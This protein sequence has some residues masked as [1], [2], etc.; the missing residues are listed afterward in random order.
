[1][2]GLLIT[3]IVCCSLMQRVTMLESRQAQQDVCTDSE[4]NRLE[5]ELICRQ[6]LIVTSVHYHLGI[7]DSAWS[8]RDLH[9]NV[10][11]QLIS[12]LHHNNYISITSYINDHQFR[13]IQSV[14]HVMIMV[15]SIQVDLVASCSTASSALRSTMPGSGRT[16]SQGSG[17]ASAAPSFVRHLS[18]SV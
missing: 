10:L 12:T 5:A 4:A 8:R 2:R 14:T 1:M 17:N 6:D 18:Q 11:P 16:L 3:V 7:R 13:V 15:N 9:C